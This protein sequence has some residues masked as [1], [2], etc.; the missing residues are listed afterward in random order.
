MRSFKL[1]DEDG[2]AK[3]AL[4]MYN[5]SASL[6]N[7]SESDTKTEVKELMESIDEL[8][9]EH[10]FPAFTSEKT[11]HTTNDDGKNEGPS[12]RRQ[13]GN[14]EGDIDLLDTCGYEVVPDETDGGTWELIDKVQHTFSI[15]D[16][17]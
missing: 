8:N 17:D 16:V 7:E 2:R 13:K 5:L 6:N 3:F 4:E 14:D 10:R 12:T 11:K 1:R 15:H 9:T